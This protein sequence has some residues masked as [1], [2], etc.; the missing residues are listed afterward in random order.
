MISSL[1]ETNRAPFDFAEGESELVSGF[2]VEY[3]AAGFALLFIGE[4][5]RII[6]ISALLS[7]LFFGG[8][9][10]RRAGLLFTLM[11]MY[12]LI[13]ARASYPRSRYDKL[14]TL[15]W[16]IILPR[17]LIALLAIIALF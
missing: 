4:Y 13:W 8:A 6:F 14:M 7:S 9:T 1:A 5:L 12:F 16:L 15:C 17:R 3:G 11:F 2:N 10:L